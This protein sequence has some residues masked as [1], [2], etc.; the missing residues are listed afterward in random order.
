M[1]M[2]PYF[3][4]LCLLNNCVAYYERHYTAI[5]GKTYDKDKNLIGVTPH[6]NYISGECNM[7]KSGFGNTILWSM[8]LDEFQS[9]PTTAREEK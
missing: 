2:C 8:P 4:E 7:I 9:S 3:Q 6:K 5:G 1:K